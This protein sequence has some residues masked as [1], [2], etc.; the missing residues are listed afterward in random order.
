M[1]SGWQTAFGDHSLLALAAPTERE[2]GMGEETD[3]DY[4]KIEREEK[5]ELP[6]RI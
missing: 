1:Q 6:W 4:R 5:D 3:K 2:G